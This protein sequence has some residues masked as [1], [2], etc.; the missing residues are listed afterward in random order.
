VSTGT[1]K[2]EGTVWVGVVYQVSVDSLKPRSHCRYI[3]M[4]VY[5]LLVRGGLR[6]RFDIVIGSVKYE[7]RTATVDCLKV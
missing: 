7:S 5:K 4:D 3:Q 2:R 6:F 1:P